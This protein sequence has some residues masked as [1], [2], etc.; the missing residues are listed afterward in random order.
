MKKSMFLILPMILVGSM[1]DAQSTPVLPPNPQP[2]PAQIRSGAP[3]QQNPKDFIIP[4]FTNTPQPLPTNYI[5]HWTNRPPWTNGS[6]WPGG[7]HS[8]MSNYPPPWHGP[9][10]GPSNLPPWRGPA[11]WS[12]YPPP[13]R[14]P[15]DGNKYPTPWRSA[16]P[17]DTNPPPWRGP[18]L[19]TN[20]LP[21]S[22]N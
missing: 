2:T 16:L 22:A 9:G 6:G 14:G 10:T 18:I 19:Q 13:W 1:A 20:N 3:Q 12:N 4:A 8:M 7:T 11:T 5:P 21:P 17:V 15:A